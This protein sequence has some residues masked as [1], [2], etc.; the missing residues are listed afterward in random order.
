MERAVI[1][2]EIITKP[3]IE[4]VVETIIK[5]VQVNNPVIIKEP[6]LI[7]V[8]KIINHYVEVPNIV[9]TYEDRIVEV[10]VYVDRIKEVR[11]VVDK[12]V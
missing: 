5:E 9:K 1:V 2:P 12:I 3:I 10:P 11:V 6:Q 8:E 7:E 4:R